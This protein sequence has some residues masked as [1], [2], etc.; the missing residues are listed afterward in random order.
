[1]PG[2][3][4]A[5]HWIDGAWV[6]SSMERPSFNPATVERIGTFC[7]RTAEV[8][9]GAI[10]AA[11]RCFRTSSWR[12]D[13]MARATA[14]SHLAD[15]FDARLNDL[16]DSLCRENS[17]LRQEATYEVHHIVRALRFASGLAVQ[18]FGH[19]ADTR[20]GLQNM[21]LREP[22]GRA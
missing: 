19:V 12:R 4:T 13:P 3:R 18:N 7:G 1:M 21:S 14:L 17:K 16:I 20:P 8:A 10:D 15:A 2:R 11:L 22:V 9:H 5:R 6:T